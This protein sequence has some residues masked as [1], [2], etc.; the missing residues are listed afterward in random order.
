M[1]EYTP[2]MVQYFKIKEKYQDC[3]LFYRL[4]D[5]YEM[6]FDDALEASKVLGITLTG[7]NCGLEERAPMCGVPFHS[8][9]S[10]IAKL[11]EK[12]YKVA[13]CEQVEDPSEAKG[14]VRRD[15]IRV[16]TPGTVTEES[17][18][19]ENR[20]NY[21]M[22]VVSE[23]VCLGFAACDI[24]TGDF[25]AAQVTWGDTLAKL[26]DEA[27]KFSPVEIV[28]ANDISDRITDILRNSTGAYISRQ[29]DGYFD[30]GE[31]QGFLEGRL[32]EGS[33]KDYDIWTR[34]SA[35][36]L[37]YVGDTRKSSLEHIRNIQNY[38]PEK[39]LVL[40]ATARRNLELT[41]NIIDGRKKGTL[42][43]VM[44]RTVT[45]MGARTLRSW[46]E[47]PLMDIN[48]IN[49][50][51]DAVGELKDTFMV[52]MEIMELLGNV[53]DLER[54]TAKLIMGNVNGRDLI[55]LKVSIDQL[56]HIKK[57]LEKASGDALSV[58]RSEIENLSALSEAIGRALV[59]QPPLA[60]TEGGIIRNGYN[61][62]VD[63]LR[64]SS[65]GGKD[66]L[67][68]FEAREREKTGIK[69]LKVGFNKVFGYYIDVTRSYYDMVPE[70]YI[71][72]QT[73][74]NNERFITEELKE[75]ETAI[76]GAEEKLIR[77][78]YNLFVELR[79]ELATHGRSLQK[80]SKALCRLDAFCS[81]AETAD[82]E[83]YCRPEISSNPVLDIR[84]GRHPV[85][86]KMPSCDTFIPN[87]TFSDNRENMVSVI[88][89]PN[90][91]GKSTF[92]RQTA[93]IVIL[94]QTGSF[95]PAQ[96]AVIG[97]C[98]RV[99]TRIGAS[100]NLAG[101]QSTFML[102]M[103]EVADI[104]NNATDRSLLILDE[105]GRGTSTFDGLAIAWSVIEYISR[106]KG[107]RTL[108]STHYHELTELEGNL[109][110]VKNYRITAEKKG[111]DV[112]FLRKVVRGSADESYGI[113]VAHL[114]GVPEGVVNR[115]AEILEDLERNDIGKRKRLKDSMK[116][117]GQMSI[118]D[119]NS[120]NEGEEYVIRNIKE[121]DAQNLT[122]LEA[123]NKLF[124]M[125]N[126]LK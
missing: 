47:Q 91:A 76:L 46:L 86:E 31:N 32:N 63:E 118:L 53:Y 88:T 26:V 72:K 75:M 38:I 123:L 35:G 40:D 29:P 64:K 79:N 27:V 71:R 5:F 41:A 109:E 23:G 77:L 115:A 52:R 111:R 92:M 97:V 80:T 84:E 70:H 90:M 62:E 3:I 44:D 7:R 89:G 60:I 58:I 6:F 117:D 22:A 19:R 102:E 78:E 61:P 87:D 105:I 9:D 120:R 49:M 125:K 73:L 34:A 126:K 36:L 85:V 96:S 69:N 59:D 51:L 43:G 56:P 104:L 15:V 57:T 124:E 28:L 42:L 83:N 30:I 25:Y 21:I 94:A 114:A 98:D 106:K 8:A 11:I 54:L 93:L 50:R 99:F 113:Q 39:F 20:N 108:F 74:A 81:L 112:I 55:A 107:C 33:Y 82:R 101:G 68:E 18:L 95:V 100:D 121:L 48:D 24:S 13:I 14:L 1:P 119:Y 10:Y 110:G 67:L 103:S 122:P 116:I 65:G 2:M 17:M 37:R 12:G 16:I 66:W 45:S 4:G